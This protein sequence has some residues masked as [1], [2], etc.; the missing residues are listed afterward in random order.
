[1]GGFGTIFGIG[2]AKVSEKGDKKKLKKEEVKE[3]LPMC[4]EEKYEMSCKELEEELDKVNKDNKGFF[5][6]P[7]VNN[8]RSISSDRN[9]RTRQERTKNN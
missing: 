4:E 8:R 7:R 6:I 9:Q 1:M 2:K 3:Y 5:L